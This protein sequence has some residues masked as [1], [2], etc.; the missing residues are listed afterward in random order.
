MFKYYLHNLLYGI[1]YL[2]QNSG[3]SFPNTSIFVLIHSSNNNL[4]NSQ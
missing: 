2:T 4:Y 1:E 3:I